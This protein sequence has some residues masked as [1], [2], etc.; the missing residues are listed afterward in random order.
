MY[1][2]VPKTLFNDDLKIEE[3]DDMELARQITLMEQEYYLKIKPVELLD[4]AWNNAKL[5]H[6]AV[7][8]SKLTRYFNQISSWIANMICLPESLRVRKSLYQKAVNITRNLFKMNNLNS[9]LALN[10][11]LQ[12]A[13]VHR[14][15]F[16]KEG[17]DSNAEKELKNIEYVLTDTKDNQKAYKTHLNEIKLQKLPTMP[18]M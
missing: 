12:N 3:I 6:R 18:Y 14:L 15:K 13:G 4:Q 9:C 2:N 1:P 5:K 17:I 10:A 11:A 16:S 7:N 8:I